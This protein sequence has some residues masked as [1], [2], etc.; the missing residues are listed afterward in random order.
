[1]WNGHLTLTR[2][3]HK[4][5]YPEGVDI[6]KQKS[7]RRHQAS[8]LLNFFAALVTSKLLPKNCPKN[9][10]PRI[11]HPFAPKCIYYTD[12]AWMVWSIYTPQI[13]NTFGT[14]FN[15]KGSSS[16]HH[17]VIVIVGTPGVNMKLEVVFIPLVFDVSFCS[18]TRGVIPDWH[19]KKTFILSACGL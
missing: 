16:N 10:R 2:W 15:R 12:L 7:P 14:R 11:P 8:L 13:F 19:L 9:S 1:M 17:I 18:K 5:K 4:K 6:Q 3:G